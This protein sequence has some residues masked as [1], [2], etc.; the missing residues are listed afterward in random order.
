MHDSHEVE[1]DSSMHATGEQD[2]DTI[3]APL[4]RAVGKRLNGAGRLKCLAA[5]DESPDGV[6]AVADDALG[7]AKRNALGLFIR[8]LEDGE[9]HVADDRGRLDRAL[10]WV[11][12][13]APLLI[14]EAQDDVIAGFGLSAEAEAQVREALS[15]RRYTRA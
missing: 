3:V 13:T 4:E 6:R 7:R 10:K 2:F 11:E 15:W 14:A 5:F 12:K 8:M 9:H 1:V